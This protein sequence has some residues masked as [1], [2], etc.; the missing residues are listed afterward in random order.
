MTH[1]IIWVFT[2]ILIMAGVPLSIVSGAW[3]LNSL[4]C[5]VGTK[6]ASKLVVKLKD[7]QILALPV[8]LMI[9][10]MT[11]LSIKINLRTVWTYLLMGVVQGW[12]GATLMTLVQE[13]T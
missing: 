13:H 5:I 6:L 9:C 3:A 11:T 2:P 4:A 7:W 10:S 1:G 12:T 8:G